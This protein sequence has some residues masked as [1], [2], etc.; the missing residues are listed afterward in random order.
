MKCITFGYLTVFMILISLLL[1]PIALAS[2]TASGILYVAALVGFGG[3]WIYGF[4]SPCPDGYYGGLR[5]VKTEPEE[6]K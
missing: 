6:K 2:P 5:K 4:F 3:W 1:I